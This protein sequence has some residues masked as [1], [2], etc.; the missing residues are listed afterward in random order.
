[1]S[2]GDSLCPLTALLTLFMPKKIKRTIFPGAIL[3]TSLY[4]SAPFT[5]GFTAGYLGTTLFHQK[6]IKTG[7]VKLVILNFREWKFHLHHWLSGSL[8][9]IILYAG[10]IIHSPLCL[11]ALGGIIFHD[12]YTDKKWYK[13]VYK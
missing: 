12:L 9:V 4:I 11:G 8:A 3:L 7:R 1:L 10:N 2:P 13:V 6:F 5:A